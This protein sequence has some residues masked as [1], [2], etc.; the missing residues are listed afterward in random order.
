MHSITL[1]I[2]EKATDMLLFRAMI[3]FNPY[4]LMPIK[5]V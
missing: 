1:L 3:E 2:V 4:L 5:V